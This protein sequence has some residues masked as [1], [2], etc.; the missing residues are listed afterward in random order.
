MFKVLQYY[1]KVDCDTLKMHAV[2]HKATIKIA[3]TYR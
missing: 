1:F 3:K 2:S